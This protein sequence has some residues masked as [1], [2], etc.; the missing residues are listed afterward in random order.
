MNAPAYFRVTHI[1]AQ[2]CRRRMRVQAVNR[3]RAVA[4]VVQLYG[5]GWYVAAVCE[6]KGR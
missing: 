5:D 1:D 6:G 2:R 4:W 3:D